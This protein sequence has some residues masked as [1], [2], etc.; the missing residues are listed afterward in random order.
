MAGLREALKGDDAAAMKKAEEE[1]TEVWHAISSEI[2]AKAKEKSSTA[3]A[4]QQAPPPAGEPQAEKKAQG[5]VVD[6]DFEVVDD[7]NKK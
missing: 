7:K 5:D 1:L 3:G 6:A 2:Y 4:E